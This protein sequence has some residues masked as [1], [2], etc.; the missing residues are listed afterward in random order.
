MRSEPNPSESGSLDVYFDLTS[1][2]P[3]LSHRMAA[4]PS[5]IPQELSPIVRW[6]QAPIVVSELVQRAVALLAVNG[7]SEAEVRQVCLELVRR[8]VVKGFARLESRN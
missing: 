1:R 6:M 2:D 4:L 8:A 5:R 3:E 7:R